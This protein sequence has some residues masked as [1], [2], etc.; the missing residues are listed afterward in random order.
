MICC[1][2][3]FRPGDYDDEFHR[4]D[5]EI[6]NFARSLDGFV[7]V[8]T[9]HSQDGT[10]VNA[11][12]FFTD[13]AAV[14]QLAG[15]PRHREAKAQVDRWYHGYRVVVSEVTASYGDDRLPI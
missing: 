4:L 8:E 11:M 15:F 14:R 1:S 9:W 12:Y 7:K 6:D 3:I 10:T 2:F 5:G 13:M